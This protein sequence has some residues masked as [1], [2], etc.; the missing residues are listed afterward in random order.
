MARAACGERGG[1]AG[2]QRGAFG[3]C[4]RRSAFWGLGLPYVMSIFEGSSEG[5]IW[6]LCEQRDR[7]RKGSR[8]RRQL[9]ANGKVRH[10]LLPPDGPHSFS[11]SGKS[12]GEQP[13]TSPTIRVEGAV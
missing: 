13:G 4:P 2:H 3:W 1:G 9:V 8:K 11:G 12:H 7:G 5:K 10:P 6:S